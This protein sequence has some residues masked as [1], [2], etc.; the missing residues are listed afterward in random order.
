MESKPEPT[1][2]QGKPWEKLS[3]EQIASGI[4]WLE[5][6]KAD[7]RPASQEQQTRRMKEKT[8]RGMKA[9][10]EAPI[11]TRHLAAR[12]A[13]ADYEN[14]RRETDMDSAHRYNSGVAA[15]CGLLGAVILPVA[16]CMAGFRDDPWLG[17]LAMVGLCGGWVLGA[18]Y[19]YFLFFYENGNAKPL[20]VRIH[21]ILGMRG[22]RLCAKGRHNWDGLPSICKRCG[23]RQFPGQYHAS[24]STQV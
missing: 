21:R 3:P 2:T 12:K 20:T 1:P 16:A 23:K 13:A 17:I 24:K 7:V 8:R 18:T 9:Y 22:E 4:E 11:E 15:F 19:A 14:E 5:R 10:L 6:T